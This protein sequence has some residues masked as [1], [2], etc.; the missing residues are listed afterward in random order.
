MSWSH[1]ASSAINCRASVTV[2][3]LM[4][5][6]LCEILEHGDFVTHAGHSSSMSEKRPSLRERKELAVA[7]TLNSWPRASRPCK[8]GM[9]L[10]EAGR[11]VCPLFTTSL[12]QPII[13]RHVYLLLQDGEYVSC[14]H[15]EDSY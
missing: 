7:W 1:H 11:C 5:L 14:E 15:D 3:P 2:V 10:Q 12:S 6:K 13:Y 4:D 8:M 9:G